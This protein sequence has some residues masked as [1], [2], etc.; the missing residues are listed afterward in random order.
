MNQISTILAIGKSLVGVGLV[1]AMFTTGTLTSNSL[2]GNMIGY[3]LIAA[4]I[5]IF[6]GVTFKTIT[7]KYQGN[8]MSTSRLIT[9]L[10]PLIFMFSL[11]VFS[12]NLFG[13]Y[14]SIITTNKI[15]SE[16][17]FFAWILFMLILIFMAIYF[18]EL[19]KEKEIGLPY[20]MFL[21]LIAIFTAVTVK[22]INVILYY[23][24]TDG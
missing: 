21:L 14:K 12:L 11:V 24:N 23:F 13:K 17:S 1:M 7:E 6:M 16:Y 22:T 5:C 18:N 15:A 8:P 20:N 19:G 4:G 10:S 2:N 9:N 3:S